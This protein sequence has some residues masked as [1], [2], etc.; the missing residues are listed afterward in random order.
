METPLVERAQKRARLSLRFGLIWLVI[1][2]IALGWNWLINGPLEPVMPGSLSR[3]GLALDR[4]LSI[5]TPL[6]FIVWVGSGVACVVTAFPGAKN[7][8]SWQGK[9][10][11]FLAVLVLLIF[12]PAAILWAL[13]VIVWYGP[14]IW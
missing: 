2:L 6:A 13:F 8:H 10:A 9:T 4:I 12:V 3:A 14:S 1:P 5:I 11:I 7:T